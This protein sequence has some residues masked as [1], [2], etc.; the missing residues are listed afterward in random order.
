[1]ST[2]NECGRIRV[3]LLVTTL[4]LLLF[5]L[6]DVAAYPCCRGFKAY[7]MPSRPAK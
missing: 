2:L 1:M 4:L 3:V 7:E 6:T 5:T